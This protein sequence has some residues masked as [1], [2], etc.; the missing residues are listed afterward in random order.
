[1]ALIV[2]TMSV[3]DVG[4][5]TMLYYY[6]GLCN[7]DITNT[8]ASSIGCQQH[9]TG[10]PHY[11]VDLATIVNPSSQMTHN[12]WSHHITHIIT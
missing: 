1:M 5:L 7:D 8:E 2:V 6:N 9:W 11:M 10:G 3:A 12:T 4:Q